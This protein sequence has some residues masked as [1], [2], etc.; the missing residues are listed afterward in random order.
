ME[1]VKNYS[2]IKNVLVAMLNALNVN[3]YKMFKLLF[4]KETKI[5]NSY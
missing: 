4:F 2:D 3:K 1:H 5:L